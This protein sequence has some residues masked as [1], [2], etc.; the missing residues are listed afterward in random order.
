MLSPQEAENSYEPSA[1]AD[2]S[3]SIL[4]ELSSTVFYTI[5]FPAHPTLVAVPYQPL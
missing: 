1:P 3:F 4:H 5:P 2:G